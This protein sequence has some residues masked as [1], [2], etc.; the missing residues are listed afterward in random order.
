MWLL[1]FRGEDFIE[2][3][4]PVTR[5]AYGGHVCFVEIESKE[6]RKTA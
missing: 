5:I 4:Q 1:C 3:D 6:G 2:I